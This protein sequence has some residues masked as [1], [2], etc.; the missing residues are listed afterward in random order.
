MTHIDTAEFYG[1]SEN[2]VGE[3]IVGQRDEV[4]L[5]S[6]V[7]PDNASHSGTMVACERSLER[8]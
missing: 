8:L 3:A 7:M 6:K 5:V 2:I 1:V 4:F